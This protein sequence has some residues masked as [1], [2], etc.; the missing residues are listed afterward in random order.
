M[1]FTY[2]M[3]MIIIIIGKFLANLPHLLSPFHGNTYE[4]ESN[5]QEIRVAQ[6]VGS[7]MNMPTSQKRT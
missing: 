7:A 6:Q 5:M 2:I 1:R 3:I 4:N